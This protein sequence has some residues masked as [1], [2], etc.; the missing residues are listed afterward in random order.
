MKHRRNTSLFLLMTAVCTHLHAQQQTLQPFSSLPYFEQSF[1]SVSEETAQEYTGNFSFLGKTYQASLRF[2]PKFLDTITVVTISSFKASDVMYLGQLLPELSSSVFGLVEIRNTKLI[3]SSGDVIENNFFYRHGLMLTGDVTLEHPLFKPIIRVTGCDPH[4]PFNA[5]I[6]I[7]LDN[8]YKS[9]LAVLIP[10]HHQITPLIALQNFKCSF[11]GMPPTIGLTAFAQIKPSVGDACVIA[12]QGGVSAA[13]EF[14]VAGSFEGVWHPLGMQHLALEKV[15]LGFSAQINPIIAPYVLPT[16]LSLA[17]KVAVG[18]KELELVAHTAAGE[19]GLIGSLNEIGLSDLLSFAAK[20]SHQKIDPEK[21]PHIEFRD[22]YLSVAP[23]SFSI[24]GLTFL[25]GITASGTLRFFNVTASATMHISEQGL[26][27]LEPLNPLALG[28][29]LVQHTK[30]G[31]LPTL[32]IAL[33]KSIPEISLQ[34]SLVVAPLINT[35]G[36]VHFG[37]NGITFNCVNSLPLG[38]GDLIHF[39]VF[40]HAPLDFVHP[41]FTV[42][43]HFLESFLAFL[44]KPLERALSD[45]DMKKWGSRIQIMSVTFDGMLDEVTQGVVPRLVIHLKIGE[46]ELELK[47]IPFNFKQPHP[48]AHDVAQKIVGAV[49]ALLGKN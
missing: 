21:I 29:L 34:G 32:K 38:L 9:E 33:E 18:T 2:I 45:G 4:T 11:M 26:H 7:P 14:S 17:G 3:L 46:H 10:S 19:V 44:K 12:V 40:G 30:A 31:L 15:G 42:S 25:S 5:S 49:Q 35:E 41:H 16:G 39:K 13:G 24:A 8:P 43:F 48:S 1:F 6:Y 28:V 37:A 27:C 22:L 23:Q 47:N 20:V 36:M